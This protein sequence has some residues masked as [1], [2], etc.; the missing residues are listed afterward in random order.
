[1]NCFYFLIQI[2]FCIICHSNVNFASEQQQQ[3]QQTTVQSKQSKAIIKTTH[4]PYAVKSSNNRVP[5]LP[6]EGSVPNL[7]QPSNPVLLPV[8]QQNYQILE[9][10]HETYHFGWTADYAPLDFR[11]YVVFSS[12]VLGSLNNERFSTGF[13]VCGGRTYNV[14]SWDSMVYEILLLRQI[15][16][17]ESFLSVKPVNSKFYQAFPDAAILHSKKL[18]QALLSRGV[19]QELPFVGLEYGAYREQGKRRTSLDQDNQA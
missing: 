1:M 13:I 5:T 11:N 4:N 18:A 2:F 10:R 17:G 16:D 6:Q 8:Y 7:V 15:S 9:R 12:L 14:K 19:E 3:D